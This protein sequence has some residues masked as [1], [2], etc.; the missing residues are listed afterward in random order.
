MKLSF[1]IRNWDNISWQEF[2]DA[3][4]NTRMAGI[5]IYDVRG[6]V[7]RGKTSPTNPELSAVTRRELIARGL[8][9]PCAGTVTDFTDSSFFVVL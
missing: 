3:A 9:I 7:F 8:S 4:Q 2:L 1:S 6:P 5:E